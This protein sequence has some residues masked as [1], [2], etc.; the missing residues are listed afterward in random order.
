MLSFHLKTVKPTN[1]LSNNFIVQK[2]SHVWNFLWKIKEL[3]MHNKSK[4]KKE[5]RKLKKRKEVLL[6]FLCRF[7]SSYSI[8]FFADSF[9]LSVQCLIIACIISLTIWFCCFQLC[10]CF[11][12]DDAEDGDGV[13]RSSWY[14]WYIFKV[15]NTFC[16]V[17]GRKN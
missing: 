1:F 2:N 12:V 9:F 15:T 10:I 5:K 11:I 16:S 8:I 3:K 13:M 4:S 14:I 6:V 17:R 7:N